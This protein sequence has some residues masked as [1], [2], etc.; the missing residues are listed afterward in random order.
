LFGVDLGGVAVHTG[1]TSTELNDRIAAR[2]FTA[3]SQ[4]YFRDG[5]PDTSASSGAELLAHELTHVVQQTGPPDL[6]RSASRVRIQRTTVGRRPAQDVV[7]GV[8]KIRRTDGQTVQRR[9]A[10]DPA[11]AKLTEDVLK[12]LPTGFAG[13]QSRVALK[14]IEIR[15]SAG[16]YDDEDLVNVRDRLNTEWTDRGRGAEMKAPFKTGKQTEMETAFQNVL[17]QLVTWSHAMPVPYGPR[18]A[19]PLKTTTGEEEVEIRAGGGKQRVVI[20]RAKQARAAIVPIGGIKFS[21]STARG[22]TGGGDPLSSVV[23]HMATTGWRGDP[24]EL[25]TMDNTYTKLPLPPQAQGTC[26]IDNRRLVAAIAAGLTDVPAITHPPTEAMDTKWA[27]EKQNA[28]RYPIWKKND[29]EI[30]VDVKRDFHKTAGPEWMLT[31]AKD[32]KPITYGDLIVIR[33]IN[34]GDMKLLPGM[35]PLGGSERVPEVTGNVF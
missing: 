25:V 21:Q 30:K 31:F 22:T 1:P 9:I 18:V 16:E 20:P 15:A 17:T 4:I 14:A 3:G 32:D 26:S 12:L 24:V 19:K 33:T 11:R 35:F 27:A 34:Q 7:R 23:E 29:G 10:D 6:H 5:L 2:A 8:S 13:G 28:T